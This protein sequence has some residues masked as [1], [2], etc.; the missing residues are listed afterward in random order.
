[1][2]VALKDFPMKIIKKYDSGTIEL[3]NANLFEQ[4]LK[5]LITIPGIALVIPAYQTDKNFDKLV[6]EITN[7]I[8][9][10]ETTT[11]KIETKRHDK[12]YEL[13]SMEFSRK[14]GHYLLINNKNLKVD[15]KQPKIKITVEIHKENFIYY[16]ER[17]KGLGGFPIGCGGK[18]LMLISGGID[19]PVAAHLL[20]KK[21]YKV[22]FVTFVSPPHTKPEALEKVHKLIKQL[23]FSCPYTPKLYVVNFTK[24][25]HEI[26][27]IFDHSYQITI[28]RRYFFRIAEHLKNTNEYDAIATGES[29]GQV[30][31]QTI[32]SM[33]TIES[34]LENTVVLRPLLTFDKLEIINIA[35]KIGT[36]EISILPFEDSCSLFVPQNPVTKPTIHKAQKLENELELISGIY[37]ITI[38]KQIKQER[39][40]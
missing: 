16:F 15:V 29:L 7:K 35:N 22:D 39:I 24:L 31:S 25:Q 13:N 12:S 10:K 17:I 6:D 5:I 1:I 26:S 20:M 30:A 23:T 19:S 3:E 14:L 2:K 28:M 40:K 34:V 38:E 33:N 18:V 21:G 36:Y 32:Q 27:H 37:N 4:V 8:S 9:L 11:F